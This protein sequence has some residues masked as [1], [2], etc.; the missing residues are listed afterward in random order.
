MFDNDVLCQDPEIRMLDNF[1][2]H[3]ECTHLIQRYNMK[4]RPLEDAHLGVRRG[5]FKDVNKVD[6][7]TR[8]IIDKIMNRFG[9]S[10]NE[11]NPGQ[12]PSVS[13]AWIPY[14]TSRAHLL[15]GA[16]ALAHK[17]CRHRDHR[18]VAKNK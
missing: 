6:T 13:C 12:R 5:F 18:K 1:L 7:T 4:I 15:A 9:F 10:V 16:A 2:T 3:D 14:C 11:M 17:L 8:A